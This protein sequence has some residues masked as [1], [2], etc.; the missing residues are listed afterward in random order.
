LYT[1]N[2]LKQFFNNLHLE[3]IEWTKNK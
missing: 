2:L 3:V 1:A